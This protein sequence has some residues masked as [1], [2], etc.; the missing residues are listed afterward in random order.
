MEISYLEGVCVH[1]VVCI[2]TQGV[3][4][5]LGLVMA[6]GWHSMRCLQNVILY[7]QVKLF[8]L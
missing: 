7:R 5:K 2:G 1:L 8:V 6:I 3:F 4:K